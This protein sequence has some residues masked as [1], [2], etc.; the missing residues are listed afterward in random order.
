MIG[1]M[2]STSQNTPA[3]D[4]TAAAEPHDDDFAA[5]ERDQLWDEVFQ[6]ILDQD[7]EE[8]RLGWLEFRRAIDEDR[9]GDQRYYPDADGEE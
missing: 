4:P 8:Q 3:G 2:M 6:A 7:P 5:Q 1:G 9:V